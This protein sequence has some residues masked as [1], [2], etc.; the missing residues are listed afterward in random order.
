M[1]NYRR[2]LIKGGTFFFTVTLKDRQSDILFRQIDLLKT[3]FQT[4]QKEKPYFTKA[5]VIL[6]E[7]LHAIWQLPENDLDYEGRWRKIKSLFTRKLAKAG[8]ISGKNKRGEYNLWQ[9]RYWEHT[10]RDEI[11]FE[12]HVN[13]IHY[14]PVKHG[15][16]KQVCDWQ[17]SSF[18]RYVKEGTLTKDWGGKII[19]GNFG[20]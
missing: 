4:V 6:P 5:I 3:A 14:N 12:N 18:H 2:N 16:V 10:I 19:S 1:V 9:P 7:H 11:D 15:L 20:E 8:I 17:Y 13:Y